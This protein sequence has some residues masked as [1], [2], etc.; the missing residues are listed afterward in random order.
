MAIFLWYYHMVDT[1]YH[2]IPYLV[3]HPTARKWVSSPQFFEWI[4]PTYPIYNP[5]TKWDESPSMVLSSMACWMIFPAKR[6]RWEF[7][8]MELINGWYLSFS[9][10]GFHKWGVPIKWMV[11]TGK[12]QSKVDDLGDSTILGKHR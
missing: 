11:Y 6:T 2:D 1:V 12:F 4:N 10:G 5:L 8:A 7:P 9:L 3:V